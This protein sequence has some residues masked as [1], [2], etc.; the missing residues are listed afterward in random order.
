MDDVS[1]MYKGINASRCLFLIK[2]CSYERHFYFLFLSEALISDRVTLLSYYLNF[3]SVSMD[4]NKI[5]KTSLFLRLSSL[6]KSAG[7]AC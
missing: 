7:A 1:K 2:L 4:T 5:T 3:D 6:L